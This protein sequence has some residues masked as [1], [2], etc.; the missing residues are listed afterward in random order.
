MPI[1]IMQYFKW[2][3]IV[4]LLIAILSAWFHYKSVVSERDLLAQNNLV[5]QDAFDKE[6]EASAKLQGLLSQSYD[7]FDRLQGTMQEMAD[8]QRH[9]RTELEALNGKFRNH[10]LEALAKKKPGLIENRVNNG[11]RDTF[12]MLEESS[13]LR[14]DGS[15]GEH[16]ANSSSTSTSTD[17]SP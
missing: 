2:G 15:S 10:D 8:N 7:R 1:P 5:L 17:K 6:K 11:T 13:K 12:R 14:A 9:A 3:G 16:N 4:I